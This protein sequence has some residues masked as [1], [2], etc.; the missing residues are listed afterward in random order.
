MRRFLVSGLIAP[1]A[2]AT[3]SVAAAQPDSPDVNCD[4]ELSKPHVVSVSGI[5]MVAVVV[6][7]IGCKGLAS[8][9]RAT[10]CVSRQGDDQEGR[11]AETT[12]YRSAQ[13][14]YP[15]EP[16]RTYVARGNGCAAIYKPITHICE[17]LGPVSATL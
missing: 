6:N 8:P 11:C 3:T 5:A 7:P 16:G 14:L 15:Y 10:A 17:P 1:L 13:V 4:Y 2:F 9:D 12:G